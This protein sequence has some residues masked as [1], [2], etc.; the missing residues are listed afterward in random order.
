MKKHH[1]QCHT[2]YLMEVIRLFNN[3]LPQY[4]IHRN[5]EDKKPIPLPFFPACA[6]PIFADF[7]ITHPGTTLPS[8]ASQPSPAQPRRLSSRRAAPNK[9]GTKKKKKRKKTPTLLIQTTS[10]ESYH[11]SPLYPPLLHHI[12]LH[13]LLPHYLCPLSHN[14]LFLNIPTEPATSLSPSA[15]PIQPMNERVKRKRK[16]RY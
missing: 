3:A 16:R 12:L 10:W 6:T 2:Y 4:V 11:P 9:P 5:G 8:K 7:I 14:S 15:C 13:I 1:I